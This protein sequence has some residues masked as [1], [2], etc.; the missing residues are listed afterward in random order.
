MISPT[1]S[2]T[3]QRGRPRTLTAMTAAER[4]RRMRERRRAAGLRAVTRW[5]PRQPA[6]ASYSSHRLIEARSLAMH[7]AIARKI[8]RD[9]TLLDIPRRNLERWAARRA[10][11]PPTWLQEW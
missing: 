8:E 9:P 4:M 3:R 6:V 5:E 10:S 1:T 11:Q 2:K 7:A